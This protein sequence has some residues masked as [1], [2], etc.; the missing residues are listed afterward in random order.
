MGFLCF[1]EEPLN[2]TVSRT[3]TSLT[4]QEEQVCSQVRVLFVYLSSSRW[5]V[6]GPP[7]LHP[8]KPP[9]WS[10]SSEHVTPRSCWTVV[11][12]QDAGLLVA[13]D[14]RGA[15]GG[16]PS[17]PQMGG[18]HDVSDASQGSERPQQ[19]ARV[20]ALV[21]ERGH[22]GGLQQARSML[23]GL[24]KRRTGQLGGAG[25]RVPLRLQGDP[26]H[27]GGGGG[28]AALWD[29]WLLLDGRLLSAGQET[30]MHYGMCS[31]RTSQRIK[32]NTPNFI[33]FICKITTVN[34][35]SAF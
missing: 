11:A 6:G 28:A 12:P 5:G 18:P 33:Y 22:V 2:R 16:D 17:G 26:G 27:R 4:K 1:L 8:V 34:K 20:E 29:P 19:G 10:G 9:S 3:R 23:T 32:V 24:E 13:P 25:G 15:S 21:V 30:L 31:F 7:P 35:L 14:Q